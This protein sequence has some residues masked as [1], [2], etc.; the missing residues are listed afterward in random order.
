MSKLKI[1]R[2]TSKQI[3][4]KFGPATKYG[5]LCVSENGNEEWVNAFSNPT[6]D[7]WQEGDEVDHPVASREY[8]GKTYYDFKFERSS[9]TNELRERVEALE[10]NVSWLISEVEL[11]KGENLKPTED[12][13]DEQLPF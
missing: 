1:K 7:A 11:M 6:S 4:T 2:K 8:N 10:K 3:N 12:P 5:F 9:P 13:E